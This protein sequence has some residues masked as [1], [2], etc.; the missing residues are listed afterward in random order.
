MMSKREPL[1]EWTDPITGEVHKCPIKYVSKIREAMVPRV[2]AVH[3]T[4]ANAL[5]LS[6]GEPTTDASQRHLRQAVQILR[7]EG[8]AIV[9]KRSSRGGYFVAATIKEL[10]DFCAI[11]EKLARSMLA[12]IDHMRAAYR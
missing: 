3:A 6:I 5:L 4:L 2:G 7:G 8:L 10:E 12:G 1:H 9:S 11:Q